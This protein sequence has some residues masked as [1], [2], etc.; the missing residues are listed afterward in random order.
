MS[1]PEEQVSSSESHY[2]LMA[3]AEAI[4]T[5]GS[6]LS[7]LVES[8][9]TSLAAV[10]SSLSAIDSTL[11]DIKT[12]LDEQDLSALTE[13]VQKIRVVAE[14]SHERSVALQVQASAY[15]LNQTR[16]AESYLDRVDAPDPVD[17]TPPD[18]ATPPIVTDG[19]EIFTPQTFDCEEGGSCSL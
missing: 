7:G 19:G 11:A 15:L 16:H 8:T 17:T 9:N 4:A 5:F 10:A 2:E 1:E 12:K 6:V 13:E 14:D 18:V 3:V